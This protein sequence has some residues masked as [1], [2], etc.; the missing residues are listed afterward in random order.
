MILNPQIIILSGDICT[1]PEVNNLFIDPLKD[2]AKKVIPFKLP[3]IKLSLLGKDGGI[4]G[5]CFY[6]IDSLLTKDFPYRIKKEGI[7]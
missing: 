3:E 7:S 5:A 1:L 2:I 4:I 6:A